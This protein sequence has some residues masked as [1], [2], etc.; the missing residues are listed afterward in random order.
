[1]SFCW[2]EALHDTLQHASSHS[3]DLLLTVDRATLQAS[4][5]CQKFIDVIAKLTVPAGTTP[6][7]TLGQ[8]GGAVYAASFNVLNITSSTFSGNTAS[9]VNITD[10]KAGRGAGGAISINSDALITS[11]CSAGLVSITGQ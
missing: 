8:G 3:F 10:F 9:R 2:K 1:M 4:K 11:S 5:L 6:D 7:P